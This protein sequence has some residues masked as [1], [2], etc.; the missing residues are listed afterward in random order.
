MKKPKERT[1]SEKDFLARCKTIYRM[2]LVRPSLF[3]LLERWVDFVM[4]YEHTWFTS[5]GQSQGRYCIDFLNSELARI[6]ANGIRTLAG[7]TE[8]YDIIQFAAVLQH[9]CQKCAEDPK[10]WHT[11][12]GFCTHDKSISG[13]F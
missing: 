6:N 2:G 7:D 13:E 11:R 5:G 8:G 3:N 4:R 12:S 9:P 10:A 1:M